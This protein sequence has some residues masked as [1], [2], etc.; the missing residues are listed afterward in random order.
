MGYT[1]ATI[2]DVI[3]K[4]NR[5]IYLPAIQR[6]FVWDPE[7]IENLFDSIMRGYPFGT[8]L[9]WEILR[10]GDPS[11]IDQYTF[12][13]FL[14]EYDERAETKFGGFKQTKLGK[15]SDLPKVVAVLDGQ[16]RIS[17]LYCA[18][19]GSYIFDKKA[20]KKISAIEYPKRELF[21]NLLGKVSEDENKYE[22]RFLISEGMNE[23]ELT[24][25]GLP[26][27]YKVKILSSF[28]SP[29]IKELERKCK[30]PTYWIRVKDVFSISS[31]A[32][33]LETTSKWAKAVRKEAKTELS[34]E[35]E[36][37]ELIFDALDNNIR[38]LWQRLV[39]EENIS[40]CVVKE[41]SLDEVLEIFVRVN[42]AGT[43][44]SKSDLVL[45][46]IV[47][48]WED[49]REKIEELIEKINDKDS[50]FNFDK[51]F[52]L[53]NCIALLDL[54]QKFQVRTF[55]DKTVPRIKSNWQKI[56]DAINSSVDLIVEFG[57]NNKTLVAQYLLTPIAYYFYKSGKKLSDISIECKKQMKIFILSGLINKIF[58]SSTESGLTKILANLKTND[59]KLKKTESFD[60]DS[61]K[62]IDFGERKLVIDEAVIDSL[63]DEPKGEISFIALSLLYPDI[64]TDRVHNWHQDHMHPF[65]HFDKKK[66]KTRLSS[67]V[68]AEQLDGIVDLLYVQSNSLINL[69]LLEGFKNQEKS[70]T[71]LV[72]WINKN[73]STERDGYLKKNYVSKDTSLEWE[74]FTDFY[75]DRKN[76]IKNRL[77][78]IFG[79]KT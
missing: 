10:E 32:K 68:P 44:L 6:K 54:E 40:V 15:P 60:Y 35:E 16:Q 38:I 11:Q 25:V 36:K 66:I 67:V 58:N 30:V 23:R 37:D 27:T 46:K 2:A 3:R 49:G 56:S 48:Q 71:P 29:E 77:M 22:F 65:S 4:L 39:Q 5:E 33:A 74:K 24:W 31:D 18:L 45:S 75:N 72:D 52:V 41:P 43:P 50:K 21:I 19:N 53:T 78:E 64:K 61:L 12:Y 17:S 13:H 8:F 69:Q 7:Q 26:N 42:S 63:L 51:D 20:N 28:N 1:S 55:T 59:G 70:D 47:A 57:F 76:N 73:Y 79:L 34:L 14:S 9:F 62:N